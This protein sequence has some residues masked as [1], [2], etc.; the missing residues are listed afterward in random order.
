MK[1]NRKLLHF[2]CLLVLLIPF[3]G[4]ANN[5][6]ISE[7]ETVL[8]KLYQTAGVFSLKKPKIKLS[9]YTKIA[10]YNLTTNTILVNRKVDVL[11]SQLSIPKADALA[12]LIG[13]ELA[14]H[15]L[16]K[17]GAYIND[18]D[19][20]RKEVEKLADIHG[21][22]LAH[23][24]GYQ[25]MEA[26]PIV[27]EEIY[28]QFNI[29]KNNSK[30]PH[31]SER[32]QYREEVIKNVAQ[33]ID[34]FEAGNFLTA[35]G[36]YDLA[37]SCYKY[38]IDHHFYF[39]KELHNNLGVVSTLYAMN[40]YEADIDYYLFPLELDPKLRIEKPKRPRDGKDTDYQKRQLRSQ[41]LMVAQQA[42]EIAISLD[43]NYT[44]GIINLI[45]VHALENKTT[46]A[47][48]LA[49]QNNRLFAHNK[50]ANEKFNL[51]MAIVYAKNE[52]AEQAIGLW[53][54]LSRSTD[55]T[56][57]YQAEYNLEVLTN[58][59][60]GKTKSYDCTTLTG[61]S[62]LP[63]ANVNFYS[64]PLRLFNKI[65]LKIKATAGVN[66][67]QF[68]NKHNQSKNILTISNSSN[69]TQISNHLFQYIDSD[70]PRY[71]ILNTPFGH[72]LSC[73][74]EGVSIL[75]YKSTNNINRVARFY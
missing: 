29:P 18:K 23:L 5:T 56:V 9:E 50:I 31:F 7:I 69:D 66:Y 25:A 57:K 68:Y 53:K 43:P 15:F 72:F 19:F 62:N 73:K 58:D 39:G 33:L 34:I 26:A 47:K 4:N 17:G 67:F 30:Y 52:E 71:D 51:A 24:A 61:I 36:K 45:C 60:F 74:K 59:H 49:H 37:T 41:Y 11:C 63:S 21:I 6:S 44:T 55:P 3:R 16:E 22:F 20:A 32:V 1:T 12:I 64:S 13:H 14:H 75:R 65:E 2:L 54:S 70:A 40:V 28:K 10:E 38:I 46:Q 48:L 42:F 27:L 35:L 8:N